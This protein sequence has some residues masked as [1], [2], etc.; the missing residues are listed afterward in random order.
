METYEADQQF[1]APSRSP[2]RSCGPTG[3]RAQTESWQVFDHI[4]ELTN[5]RLEL[6]HVPF[7]DSVEK[8]SLLISAGDAPDLIPLIYR[9]DETPFVSSGAILPLSDFIEHMPHFR[10]YVQEWELGDMI[11]TLRQADG[12]YYMLPGLQEVW[13]P[14]FSLIIRTDVWEEVGI[15]VPSTWDE[16]HEGLRA[17]KERYPESLPLADGFEGQSLINYGGYAFGTRAG[18]GFGDGMVGGHDGGPLEYAATTVE[19]REMVE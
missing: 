10:K 14:S 2:C 12:K 13:V 16:V 7:S 3:R 6:V 5:V 19:Y 8:R 17:I 4:E 15:G 1:T 11:D 9:G 18:W